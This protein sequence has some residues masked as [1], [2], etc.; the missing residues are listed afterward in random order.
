M[1]MRNRIV[2]L[3]Y[4]GE[5]RSRVKVCKRAVPV[6]KHGSIYDTVK[7]F[8]HNLFPGVKNSI[9]VSKPV[10][11]PVPLRSIVNL[12]NHNGIRSINR[13]RSMLSHITGGGHIFSRGGMPNIKLTRGS[14]GAWILFDGHHSLLA[15]MMA[16]KEFLHEIPHII[17]ENTEPGFTTDSE[18]TAFFGAHARE[19][20]SGLG[21]W[22]RYA[23]NWQAPARE[24]LCARLQRNMGEL[25]DDI[26]GF[27]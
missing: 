7:F 9:F 12:H 19:L 4:P 6:E 3:V 8:R 27:W 16:G 2:K 22:K 20:K 15:Y 14:D 10:S 1:E 21:C 24:Q 11:E 26:F 17:V 18:I 25:A 23:I 5:S 13:I